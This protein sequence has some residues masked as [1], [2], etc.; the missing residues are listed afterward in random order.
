MTA[1]KPFITPVEPSEIPVVEEIILPVG[2]V[3]LV[4]VLL[5]IFD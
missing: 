2:R 1:N 5:T 4:M 3:K